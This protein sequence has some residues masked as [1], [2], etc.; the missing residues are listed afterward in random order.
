[1]KNLTHIAIDGR[2]ANIESRVGSNVYAFE[3]ISSIYKLLEK[4]DDIKVTV[5]LAN[6]KIDSMPE[7]REGWSYKVFGPQK[8]WTQWA[9]PIHLFQHQTNYDVFFTPGHY[10]PRL[11]PIPYVSSV[12]DTAYI[13]YPDQFKKSDTLKL[14]KW[15]KYSVKNAQKV[16]A[17]S[18]YTKNEVI[19]H[20]NILPENIVVA[21]PA[22]RTRKLKV[23]AKETNAFFKKNKIT[24][25]Y[26]VFVG[27][28]QPRKNIIKL[29]EAFE[30]FSRMKAGRGLKKKTKQ[31]EI[32]SQKRVKLVLAGKVGWLAD[33]IIKKIDNSPIK[34][35]I[36]TTGFVSEKEKQILYKYAFAS[37]LGGTHEGFGIPPLESLHFG[38]PP[39]VSNTTS[40]PEVVGDAG[41]L[42]EPNSPQDIAN[43]M[44][45]VFSMP[46][47][48]KGIFRKKAREQIKKFSWTNSAEIILNTLLEVAEQKDKQQANT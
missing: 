39:I 33:D 4:R 3:I 37:C 45:E 31:R 21:Y 1:M 18:Q 46:T 12:M 30:I 36:V 25:P 15:T 42:V 26:V 32:D 27:T 48:E 47:R 11:S 29:V 7:K 2:E 20:Y 43:K 41:F 5:L 17:I 8:F 38:T 6:K 14:T 13:N 19:K 24:E 35:K 34:N 44:W 16:I 40:L 9:L 22:A 10:A 23:N 28:L